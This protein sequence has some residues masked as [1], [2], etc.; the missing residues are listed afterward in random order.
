[1]HIED[2]LTSKHYAKLL[3]KFGPYTG[4]LVYTTFG[5]VTGRALTTSTT[6]RKTYP[7]VTGAISITSGT[8][9]YRKNGGSWVATPGTLIPTD[10]VEANVTSSGSY[11]TAV[12]LVF[13]IDG[14]ADTFTVTT[15]VE[16]TTGFPYTFPFELG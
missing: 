10:Y 16:L 5:S 1:M 3:V 7:G 9:T 2:K 15:G 8:G 14:G 6:S 11:E 4:A 13:S 12:E